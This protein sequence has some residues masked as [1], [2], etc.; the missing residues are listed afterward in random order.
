MQVSPRFPSFTIPDFTSTH[1]RRATSRSFLIE[2]ASRPVCLSSTR[3]NPLWVWR[4]AVCTSYPI[5]FVPQRRSALTS[6]AFHGLG[7]RAT[8][9]VSLSAR[10]VLD[11]RQPIPVCL[12][13]EVGSAFSKRVDPDRSHELRYD[14]G[15]QGQVQRLQASTF[16]GV[17][18]APLQESLLA[19]LLVRRSLT[20]SLC[21]SG[22]SPS[23]EQGL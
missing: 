19:L 21:R 20:L 18:S 9:P 15:A 2:P 13:G 7:F 16:V 12:L 17:Q 4:A 5:L 22:I 8:P 3:L 11:R 23:P 10:Q 6:R 14:P 1:T